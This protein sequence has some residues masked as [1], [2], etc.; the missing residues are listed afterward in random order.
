MMAVVASNW[1]VIAYSRVT[2]LGNFRR[3]SSIRH[4]NSCDPALTHIAYTLTRF[5]PMTMVLRLRCSLLRFAESTLNVSPIRKTGGRSLSSKL[6][7]AYFNLAPSGHTT[8]V[9]R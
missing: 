2:R 8:W 9:L 3:V 4:C 7:M 5:A 6:V 1:T